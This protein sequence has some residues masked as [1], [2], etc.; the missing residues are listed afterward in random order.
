L[1]RHILTRPV[2]AGHDR[3][4]GDLGLTHNAADACD[5]AVEETAMNHE[6]TVVIWLAVSGLA[7]L[8]ATA[9]VWA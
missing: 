6:E 2:R 7:L 9:W 8:L 4:Q 3:Y 1:S 5:F